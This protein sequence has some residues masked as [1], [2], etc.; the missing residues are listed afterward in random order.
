MFFESYPSVY[1]NLFLEKPNLIDQIWPFESNTNQETS[2]FYTALMEYLIDKRNAVWDN[3]I[4]WKFNLH[5]SP[6]TAM[7]E[8]Q[9]LSQNINSPATIRRLLE[10]KQEFF[11]SK[12][13]LKCLKNSTLIS[14]NLDYFITAFYKLWTKSVSHEQ[15]KFANF[16]LYHSQNLSLHTI[17]SYPNA[18]TNFS[19]R[20]WILIVQQTLTSKC[21][22]IKKYLCETLKNETQFVNFLCSIQL[23]N[24]FRTF[25]IS[26]L[27]TES[28]FQILFQ[29]KL[30]EPLDWICNQNLPL[31]NPNLEVLQNILFDTLYVHYWLY[32]Q[33][34]NVEQAEK[35]F[36]L[37]KF[38][39]SRL[40]NEKR[41]KTSKLKSLFGT[42]D[43]NTTLFTGWL[44]LN[45]YNFYAVQLD[46][47]TNK[48]R[49]KDENKIIISISDVP[50]YL[51]SI[52]LY[53]H[54]SFD[55]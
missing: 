16:M 15:E 23:T 29:N 53:S 45:P 35:I 18:I 2:P 40:N 8:P 10:T 39:F 52:Y 55:S 6:S 44:V 36:E 26:R 5:V 4:V 1:R 22:P 25:T 33:D 21:C 3:M 48:K 20:E 37:N 34:L 31:I 27:Q 50:W 13:F 30:K 43:I 9:K 11:Y 54:V 17:L 38:E 19:D 12:L 14:D 49:Q 46:K 32:K 28:E 24:D 42:F 47:K 51:S 7:R 41:V